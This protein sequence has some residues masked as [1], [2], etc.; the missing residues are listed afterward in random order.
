MSLKSEL[1]SGNIVFLITAAFI[2]I[3]MFLIIVSVSLSCNTIEGYDNINPDLSV[4]LSGECFIDYNFYHAV[5]T[6]I[7]IAFGLIIV[8]VFL[9]VLVWTA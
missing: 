8:G 7:P 3:T 4:G 5:L 6:F 1:L 9:S 2:I